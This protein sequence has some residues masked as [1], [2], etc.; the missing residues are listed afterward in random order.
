MRRARILEDIRERGAATIADLARTHAISSMTAHRDLEHLAREGLVVRVRGGARALEAPAPHPTAWEARIAQ[1]PEAKAAIAEH[2]LRHVEDGATVF[3]DASSTAHALA[4]AIMAAPPLELTLV[5]NSPFIAANI[6]AES[7]HVV[8][9][10]GEL[11]QQTRAVTGRWTVDFVRRLNVDV[12]FISAAGITLDTGLTTSR[13]PIADVL[14]AARAQAG[15][16]V[17]LVDATKFGRAA[18][19][20]IA[21]AQELDALVTDASLGRGAVDEYRGAGVPLVVAPAHG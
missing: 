10:P 18:L 2:A 19:V 17:G 15:R 9:C 4:L 21:R 3:L 5:T 6:D 13:S 16:T 20:T 7:V 11:D 12:A 14:N 8:V 1:E